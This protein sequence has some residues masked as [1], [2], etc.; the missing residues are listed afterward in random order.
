MKI[1]FVSDIH[2]EFLGYNWILSDTDCDLV[3]LAGDIGAGIFTYEWAAREAE[4]LKKPI[5]II[6]GNHEYYNYI[7][8]F[9]LIEDAKKYLKDTDVHV[10]DRDVFEFQGYK[11][12]G[13]TLWTDYLLYGK[14][15]RKTAMQACQKF[16]N[17]HR[18]INYEGHVF[19][20]EDALKEFKKSFKWLNKELQTTA[21]KIVVTHH[22]PT[23]HASHPMYR[24]DM[25][26]PGFVSDLEGFIIERKPLLWISGHSHYCYKRQIGDTLCISNTKGYRNEGVIGFD[27]ELIVEV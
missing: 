21:K 9:N 15:L 6:A 18:L 27:P 1:N 4:R 19:T 13:A 2:L 11:I 17:D 26:T 24:G 5:V 22:G 10:L 12:F 7:N 16:M 25:C 3:I 8:D 14:K 20:P 23:F